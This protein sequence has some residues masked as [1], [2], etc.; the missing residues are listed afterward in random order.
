[1]PYGMDADMAAALG[2]VDASFNANTDG[3]VGTNI[4][5][6]AA[7]G[8]PGTPAVSNEWASWLRGLGTSVVGYSIARDAARN[9]IGLGNGSARPGG[10]NYGSG[11]AGA[12]QQTQPGGGLLKLAALV[13]IIWAVAK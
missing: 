8:T 1:M 7:G 2:L 4:V 5:Q 9:G 12:G 13:A 6:Q 11:S 3:T 10:G